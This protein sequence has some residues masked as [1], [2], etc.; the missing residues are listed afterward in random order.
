MKHHLFSRFLS[1]ITIFALSWTLVSADQLPDE[2]KAAKLN[3]YGTEF[4]NLSWG[5]INAIKSKQLMQNIGGKWVMLDRIDVSQDKIEKGCKENS[6]TFTIID[7][8]SFS[9]Q[10]DKGD[11]TDIYINKTGLLY[12]VR[13]DYKARIDQQLAAL[14]NSSP[15]TRESAASGLLQ[16]AN[17]ESLLVLYSPNVLLEIGTSNGFPLLYGRCPK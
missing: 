15:A 2:F 8:Y 17:Q 14:G 16:Y 10:W 4:G 11:G 9:R 1:S 3:I 12:N 7:E 5:G 6:V 13:K